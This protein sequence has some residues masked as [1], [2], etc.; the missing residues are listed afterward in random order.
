VKLGME[1]ALRPITAVAE[2]AIGL[3]GGD[4][5]SEKR[6]RNR[7]R[8]LN[9]SREKLNARGADV[10]DDP[11]PSVIKPLLSAAQEESRDELLDVFASLVATAMDPKT[12]GQYRREFVDIAKELEPVD[13]LV[14][15]I[16]DTTGH[17]EP[18][19]AIFIMNTLG[20][21]RDEYEISRQN[22]ARLNLL[23]TRSGESKLSPSIT[24]LGR[25]FVR[26]VKQD[27]FKDGRN[28]E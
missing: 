16:F 25:L 12:R 20:I 19:R 3:L 2:N 1:V 13:A 14:L 15:P 18:S 7:E 17:L 9:K 10:D 4:W 6:Q 5:L 27:P 22:L 26:A 24:P 21:T 8:L 11:S 28:P 23:N